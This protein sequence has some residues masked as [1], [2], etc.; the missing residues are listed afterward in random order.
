MC[1][2]HYRASEIATLTNAQMR[3]LLEQCPAMV[4]D[5]MVLQNK[6]LA[7]VPG[8]DVTGHL[9]GPAGVVLIVHFDYLQ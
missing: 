1:V 3:E 9:H 4:V 7:D 5:V 8:G 6:Q 2:T